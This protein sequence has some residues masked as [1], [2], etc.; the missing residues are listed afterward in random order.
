MAA[1][2]YDIKS[3]V[4]KNRAQFPRS[5][6]LVK[7][8][9]FAAQNVANTESAEFVVIPGGTFVRAFTPIIATAE[10]GAATMTVGTETSA[11]LMGT[12]DLDAAAGSVRAVAELNQD[13]SAAY[14]EAEAQAV[15]DKVDEI[16]TQLGTN[17]LH[18]W[19]FA[20]DTPLRATAAADLDTAKV[21]LVFDCLS[22]DA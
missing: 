14:V 21:H 11:A 8:I 1:A 19:Y 5:Y 20:E 10:G 6:P 12:V 3:L 13:A 17:G 15:A 2:T 4:G 18:G 7:T 9:D 22:V 16:I